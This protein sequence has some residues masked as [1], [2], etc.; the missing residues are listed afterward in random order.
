MAAL[1]PTRAGGVFYLEGPDGADEYR[2]LAPRF[3]LPSFSAIRV[4]GIDMYQ[5]SHVSLS[6]RQEDVMNHYQIQLLRYINL[7]GTASSR[8]RGIYGGELSPLKAEGFVKVNPGG[9]Q[10]EITR[11]GVEFLTSI[12]AETFGNPEWGNETFAGMLRRESFY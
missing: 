7:G 12:G 3:W 6:Y 8:V 4:S 5:T 10:L 2:S 11:K 9:N 1:C